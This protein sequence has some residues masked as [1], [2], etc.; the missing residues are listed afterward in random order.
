VAGENA[1]TDSIEQALAY[2]ARGWPIFP[3]RNKNT[4]RLKWGAAA[5]NDPVQ[6]TKWWTAWPHDLIGM[7]T[8]RRS[9][10][11][12]LDVD[13][14][15]PKAYGPDTLADLGCSILPETPI[16]HT[17]SCGF[18]VFFADRQDI[19]IRNSIGKHGLG[20]GLDIRGTGGFVILPSPESGYRWDLHWNFDTVEPCPA[21]V[22][23]GRRSRERHQAQT[24]ARRK[25]DARSVLEQACE[26]I[27]NAEEGDKYRALRRECFIVAC[28]VRDRLVDEWRARHELDA[29]ILSLKSRCSDFAHAVKGYEG[30]WAEGLAASP[31][32][33]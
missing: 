28:L 11:V 7:A 25:F 20:P 8:G 30:A 23:L 31:R 13:T 16:A 27:R 3:C 14:K 26:N 22:W 19:E 18:H 32:R 33:P 6:I 17:R 29:A 5:T 2:A 9:G 24:A 21:P 15:E 12:V 1:M 10:L 4:H